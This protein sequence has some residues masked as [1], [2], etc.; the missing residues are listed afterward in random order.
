M[1]SNA[2]FVFLKPHALTDQA[3]ALVREA[4]QENGL[5]ILDY[6]RLLAEHIDR[7]QLVDKHFYEIGSKACILKPDQLQ[8]PADIFRSAF[9]VAWSDVLRS[10]LAYNA[11]DACRDYD[12]SVL[13]LATLWTKARE[14]K[15]VVKLGAGYYCGQLEVNGKQIYVIN[16]F[17]LAV[18]SEY[19]QMGSG[20]Y[21]FV[22]EWN[23]SVMP[24]S[25]FR[26]KIIGSDDPA[27]AE[28]SSIRGQ[29]LARWKQ[30][31]LKC[32]PSAAQNGIHASASALDA[33]VERCNWLPR[34]LPVA[35]DAL[36]KQLLEAG[37]TAAQVESWIS[38]PV[39]PLYYGGVSP[40]PLLEVLDGMDSDR[41]LTAF[42]SLGPTPV[43][44]QNCA[45][46]FVKPHALTEA[47]VSLTRSFL[48]QRG[49][50]IE[51]E[52]RIDGST[53]DK[54]MMIDKHYYQIASKATI[55]RPEHVHVPKDEFKSKFG[56]NWNV[57]LLSGRALGVLEACQ[58]LGVDEVGLS[59]LWTRAKEK[60]LVLKI[61]NGLHCGK[62]VKG[63]LSVY[64]FNGFFMAVRY[65]YVRPTA[66]IHAFVVRWDQLHL[67]WADFRME[68]IGAEDPH[69]ASADS[70]RGVLRAQWQKLAIDPMPSLANNCVHASA[71]PLEGLLERM[72]WL[73]WSAAEDIFGQRLLAAGID[74]ETLAH[75][76]LDPKLDEDVAP[77]ANSIFS[78]M[79]DADAD[80][81][82]SLCKAIDGSSDGS[83]TCK[84]RA[85]LLLKPDANSKK[86]V[87]LVKAILAREGV[88]VLL[89]K[90]VAASAIEE[91]ELVD[92]HFRKTGLHA[93]LD[94]PA[95][96]HVS[97]RQFKAFFGTEW[98]DVLLKGTAFNALDAL[99]ALKT[100]ARGLGMLWATAKAAGLVLR[101]GEGLQL[102][103]LRQQG[104]HAT[105][106]YVFNGLYPSL[107]QPY[108][109]RGAA[110]YLF[111]IEW[112]ALTLPWNEFL[113][114]VVGAEDPLEAT[115]ASIRG[116]LLTHWSELGLRAAPTAMSNG[117]YASGSALEGLIDR[118]NWL[119]DTELSTDP[120]ACEA[121]A[122]G[123]DEAQLEQWVKNPAVLPWPSLQAQ[124]LLESMAGCDADACFHRCLNTLNLQPPAQRLS[125][126]FVFLQ[127]GACTPA[128]ISELRQGLLAWGMKILEDGDVSSRR[129][130]EK[131]LVDMHFY[132]KGAKAPPAISTED[133]WSRALKAGDVTNAIDACRKFSLTATEL[134][135]FWQ[136]AAAKGQV[137]NFGEDF[138]CARLD[139][140]SGNG[141]QVVKKT[142]SVGFSP[143]Y[144]P[145]SKATYV[146]NGDF[147][148][149]RD[150]YVNPKG[151]IHYFVVEW[152]STRL[153]WADFSLRVIGQ[154]V[155]SNAPAN[156]LCGILMRRWEHLGLAA[157]PRGADD[158][159]H[160]S[161]SQLAGLVERMNWLGLSPENDPWGKALLTDAG[162][163]KERL[164]EWARNPRVPVVSAGSS[165]AFRHVLDVVEGMD[166]KCCLL[167]CR[168]LA[169]T[170]QEDD[171]ASH[172]QPPG[173]TN[174]EAAAVALRYCFVELSKRHVAAVR[175]LRRSAYEKYSK[176]CRDAA[177]P[178]VLNVL[179]N[180][181]G[182]GAKQLSRICPAAL[183][184]HLLKE[185][186]SQFNFMQSFQTRF[187]TVA[188]GRLYWSLERPEES[189]EGL[190]LQHKGFVDLCKN[191]CI[192]ERLPDSPDKFVLR[193]QGPSWR[194]GSFKGV[195]EGRQF[196]FDAFSS[197][198]RVEKWLQTISA[199]VSYGEARRLDP[200]ADIAEE[201][202]FASTD[203]SAL[204]E[205]EDDEQLE[206]APEG[207]GTG[208]IAAISGWWSA[209]TGAS[210]E[211]Q[212]EDPETA[213]EKA[214]VRIQTAQR[215][216]AGR[217]KVRRIRLEC[218]EDV[219]RGTQE[220][221]AD[222][223]GPEEAPAPIAPDLAA[224]AGEDQLQGLQTLGE[225][226]TTPVEA[227]A[228]ELDDAQAAIV[229]GPAA[230]AE[231]QAQP[232][233]SSKPTEADAQG[234]E[235]ARAAIVS[236]LAAKAAGGELPGLLT[237][238]TQPTQSSTPPEA[239]AQGLEDA[240]AAIASSL[241]AK[242]AG[243]EL[244]G[245][246]TQATQAT[247]SSTPPEAS[248]P[249]AEA[250]AAPA[251]QP[252]GSTTDALPRAEAQA[253]P[254]TKAEAQSPPTAAVRA[255]AAVPPGPSEEELAW[256]M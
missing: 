171:P 205:N 160:S 152:D 145:P 72:N 106:I 210:E 209:L 17:F 115:S 117:L 46:V 179:Q 180:V 234:L 177:K 204:G 189:A 123:I 143:A 92:K 219:Q 191:E 6:G 107:R 237:Q 161:S 195:K 113:S 249:A 186:P 15:K 50:S 1:I 45:L 53:I 168:E 202:D 215:G 60:G 54:R 79:E 250:E 65:Q 16:G 12:M 248:P 78:V 164:A 231:G 90:A 89:E 63:G 102:A 80:R 167:K 58:E 82:I 146:M 52:G 132:Q 183:S 27:T 70:L 59:A 200:D 68:V 33:L 142:R 99:K 208:F 11:S 95:D 220:D 56:E 20:I 232:M 172:F 224:E 253:S 103:C 49:L 37:V 201:E 226:G 118:L 128:A 227:C 83:C 163:S 5:R 14:Q 203:C 236:S 235:D 193:P 97:R 61:D 211:M 7:S 87:A 9:G 108:V 69:E 155:A 182:V 4:F 140:S 223:E 149:T 44:S 141:A 178:V 255:D 176:S 165:G 157:K 144:G 217:R 124:P 18:R 185:N 119:P 48:R 55:L 121:L 229:A 127:P 94:K 133:D 47:V 198:H 169:Q 34:S 114:G 10:G 254:P 130:R 251:P 39:A 32:C 194:W 214:A 74:D 23:S 184:G 162:V 31:K 67:S 241:A 120:F 245:L 159:V 187:I 213:R 38:N 154:E 104:D 216:K 41:V 76:A 175:L 98:Q 100:D 64:V 57:V 73:G 218:D 173:P 81:C 181:L 225:Q 129:I 199:H 35:S 101:L 153:S 137:A 42:R 228:E 36:G 256:L 206:D 212:S 77:G 8:V 221:K 21:F 246:L 150:R 197:E 170:P 110:V 116:M 26:S 66:A 126:A 158:G 174:R 139:F 24:W 25:D 88:E 30:L 93:S 40:T 109:Q 13:D 207:E 138:L 230:D 91:L 75:W 244:P 192:V 86:T 222:A 131:M 147:L 105:D 85:V 238:A 19:V 112:N 135:K 96:L 233:Q 29:L 28:A 240:R 151:G 51:W 22:V 242:A 136:Q 247:Q 134:V 252:E 122:A 71:S 43:S 111:F 239:D 190:P 148:E 125:R 188:G 62:L 166:A 3:I 196:V 243:G 156:S 84:N 2:A